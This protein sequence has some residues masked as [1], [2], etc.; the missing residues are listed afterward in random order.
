MTSIA[1]LTYFRLISTQSK[2]PTEFPQAHGDSSQSPYNPIPIPVGIPWESPYPRQPCQPLVHTGVKVN[3][4]HLNIDV[5]LLLT[6]GRL[7]ERIIVAKQ[8]NGWEF[9]LMWS[10]YGPWYVIA[11]ER[12]ESSSPYSWCFLPRLPILTNAFRLFLQLMLCNV[13]GGSRQ[14]MRVCIPHQHIASERRTFK[15]EIAQIC[16]IKI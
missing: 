3:G 5:A 8:M 6:V 4:V 7:Y 2:I 12:I 10:F 14:G 1:H 13:S 16:V 11:I 9:H 15:F